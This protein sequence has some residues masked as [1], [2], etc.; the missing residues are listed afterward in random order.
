MIVSF[1]SSATPVLYAPTSSKRLV[2]PRIVRTWVVRAA[3]LPSRWYCC[4]YLGQGSA[5]HQHGVWCYV[6]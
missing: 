4:W 1:K 2:R 5:V 3:S 6:W